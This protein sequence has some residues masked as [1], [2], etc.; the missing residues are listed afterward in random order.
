MHLMMGIR[1][2]LIA[3]EQKII[4]LEEQLGV[5][6]LL[7]LGG[8]WLFMKQKRS[9]MEGVSDIELMS[10][11]FVVYSLLLLFFYISLIKLALDHFATSKLF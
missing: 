5:N 1:L 2:Y 11:Y 7:F 8:G 3:V 6:E 10:S 4:M 9:G